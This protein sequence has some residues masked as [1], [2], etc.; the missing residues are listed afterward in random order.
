MLAAIALVVIGVL[1]FV[2][3][4]VRSTFMIVVLAVIGL[5]LGFWLGP[6]DTVAPPEEVAVGA[7]HGSVGTSWN[8]C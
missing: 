7:A 4:A 8:C 5:A 3:A 2:A 1:L 6:T